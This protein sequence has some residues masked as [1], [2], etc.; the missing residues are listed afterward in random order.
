MRNEI[1]IENASIK[2]F[3]MDLIKNL[4]EE[5]FQQQVNCKKNLSNLWRYNN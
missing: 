5:K 4:E 3:L 2:D 1:I